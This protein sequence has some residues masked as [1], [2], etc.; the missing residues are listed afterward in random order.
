MKI[1]MNVPGNR[2]QVL[3]TVPGCVQYTQG[4]QD[5]LLY[6]KKIKNLG[7]KGLTN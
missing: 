7:F 2:V 4:L 3:C 5:I 1:Q 6:N